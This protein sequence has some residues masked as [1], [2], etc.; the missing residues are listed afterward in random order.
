MS[1][2]CGDVLSLEDLKTAKKHQTFEAEVITGK[3]G[4]V[5]SGADIDYA[6]NQVTGQTQK[7]L[8]AILR[9][10]GFQQAA[11]TFQTGGTLGVNDRNKVVYD[12]ASMAWYSWSGALPK[13]VPAGTNPLLDAN[14]TPQ[15]DPN[16]RNELASQ[17]GL[18]LIGQVSTLSAL[19]NVEP[20]TNGQRIFVRQ[21]SGST[22]K[23]GGV[24]QAVI[25]GGSYTDNNGTVAKTPGG[26]AWLRT[27]ADITNPLMFGAVGDGV[28]SGDLAAI[29]AAIANSSEVDLLGLTYTLYGAAVL[30]DQSGRCRA[31]NGILK[32]STTGNNNMMYVSGTNKT[33]EN[34]TFIGTDG[35]TSRGII[36]RGGSSDCT[37]RNNF[38]YDFKNY[39]VC[40]AYDYTN[41]L[42]CDRI[43]VEENKFQLCGRSATSFSRSSILLDQAFSCT[44]ANNTL[45]Q[46]NWGI[47][48]S[49]PFT[50][51]N[52]TEPFG[53]YNVIRGNR[54]TGSGK[55]GNPYSESQGISA[56]SQKHL[57]VVNNIVEQFNGNGIDNQRCEFSVI[58]GN[59]VRDCYDGFFI[60]DMAFIGHNISSNTTV[61]CERGIRCLNSGGGS[62]TGQSMRSSLISNNN[63]IDSTLV[64]IYL[65]RTDTTGTMDSIIV[66]GNEVNNTNSRANA[67]NVC[68]IQATGLR[69]SQV[70]NNSVMNSRGYAIIIENCLGTQF[71]DN[72]VNGYDFVGLSRAAVYIDSAC[73]GVSIRNLLSVGPTTAGPAVYINGTSNTAIGTRWRGPASG[74]LNSGTSSQVSDNFVF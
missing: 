73:V 11:F 54:I 53:F 2:G 8:P 48:L 35:P 47:S 42:R 50:A 19:R 49:Q 55:T 26:A 64:G 72:A 33:V 70:N 31:F 34:I 29:N 4:G 41:N 66:T 38:F 44:V 57:T 23:G 10:A 18:K 16:L 39:G 5:T 65:Y 17:D 24:F 13:V 52:P 67:A 1:S 6:T 68:G 14:W 45:L 22:G 7:T 61:N 60:G 30:M 58:L 40:V 74:I 32:D 9:D 21:H 46:C 27:N 69:Y 51:P 28:A 25:S 56:Q 37:I 12:S 36:V 20:T 3:A 43:T 71:H 15:T 59:T 62:F 63:F